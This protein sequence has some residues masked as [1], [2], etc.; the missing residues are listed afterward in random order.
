MSAHSG[1]ANS[2]MKYLTQ[3]IFSNIKS[4]YNSPYR[5]KLYSFAN[6]RPSDG[7]NTKEHKTDE[8]EN[9]AFAAK[10]WLNTKGRP[11]PYSRI[12]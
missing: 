9:R 1:G 11:T 12:M 5:K 3:R 2:V 7:P 4:L 6:P 10:Y 8:I